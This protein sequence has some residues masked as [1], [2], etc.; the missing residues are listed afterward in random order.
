[1]PPGGLTRLEGPTFQ[2]KEGQV[3]G[4]GR[5]PGPC[6][7]LDFKPPRQV[8][9]RE[10]GI[11]VLDPGSDQGLIVLEEGVGRINPIYAV[12]PILQEDGSYF[13]QVAR[14]G[15]FSYYEFA[16]PGSDRLTDERWRA[17][18]DD[19]TAPDVPAWT[20]SF[21]VNSGEYEALRSG[22]FYSA[23][24]Q[25]DALW[26]PACYVDNLEYYPSLQSMAAELT[27]LRDNQQYIGH[28]LLS[29]HFLSYDLVS[30]T[31]A[32]VTVRET[33][34]DMLYAGEWP[35]DGAPVLGTRP[36]YEVVATYTLQLS[37]NNYDWDATGVSYS[38][39]IPEWVAP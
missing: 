3:E 35:E 34:E 25:I 36:Q 32:V 31:Q 22:V 9:R 23:K 26:C 17:M 28:Q 2:G 38:T 19:G 12:V 13:W 18:L 15:V 7:A 33:W 21:R 8:P 39:P 20:A 11:P 5:V 10:E 27:T 37:D 6:H 1:M 14:G 24:A 29:Q 30:E 16:W 4:V